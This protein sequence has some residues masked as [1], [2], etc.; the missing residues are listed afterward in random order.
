M[1]PK[2]IRKRP[3]YASEKSILPKKGKRR[4]RQLS[5]LEED[6]LFWS[7][8]LMSGSGSIL[9]KKGKKRSRQLSELEEDA[10]F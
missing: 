4:S 8:Q 6:T 10:L 9:P 5:E 7:H 1:H 2:E 3:I